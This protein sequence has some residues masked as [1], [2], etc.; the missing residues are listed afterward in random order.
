M[1][2]YCYKNKIPL[3]RISYNKIN[4]ISQ[5]INEFMNKLKTEKILIYY[6]DDKLYNYLK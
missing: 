1:I 2:D 5:I 3:L 6:S 4:E